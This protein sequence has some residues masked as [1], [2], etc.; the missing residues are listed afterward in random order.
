MPETVG[1]STMEEAGQMHLGR[2]LGREV[3]KIQA[4]TRWWNLRQEW[5]YYSV[6]LCHQRSALSSIANP[7]LSPVL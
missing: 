7:T 5:L 1:L 4:D 6:R 3:D 2:T